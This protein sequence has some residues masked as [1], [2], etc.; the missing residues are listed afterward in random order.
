M[1]PAINDTNIK[2]RTEEFIKM[3][4]TKADMYATNDLLFPFGCDFEFTNVRAQNLLNSV[5]LTNKPT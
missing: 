4:R 2:N 5:L 1:N 3:W